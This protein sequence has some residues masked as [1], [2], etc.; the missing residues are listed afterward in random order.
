MW[1]GWGSGVRRFLPPCLLVLFLLWASVFSPQSGRPAQPENKSGFGV[2]FSASLP[3]PSPSAPASY[4]IDVYSLTP[5]APRKT[6]TIKIDPIGDHFVGG[7]PF[8]VHAE[9]DSHLPIS[10]SVKDGPAILSG[11]HVTVLGIGKVR[12]E[13]TQAGNFEYSPAKPQTI[14]FAV[15]DSQNYNNCVPGLFPLAIW[16]NRPSQPDKHSIASRVIS[17]LGSPAPFSFAP[18]GDDEILVYSSRYP[19]TATDKRKLVQIKASISKLLAIPDLYSPATNAPESPVPNATS[20]QVPAPAY[21]LEV[22]VPHAAALGDLASAVSALNS[23]LFK[24]QDAGPGK[25][26]ITSSSLPTCHAITRFLYDIRNLAWQ[27]R[28]V[29]PVGQVFHLSASDV[30]GALNGTGGQAGAGASSGSTPTPSAAS[31]TSSS[32]TAAAGASGQA[33][34]SPGSPATTSAAPAGTSSAQVSS[35][36][37]D[38]LL[39]SNNG[40]GGDAGIEQQKRILALLDLPRPD[41]IINVW[42]VQESTT[43]REAVGQFSGMLNETVTS[44]NDGLQE[45]ILRGWTYLN[46]QITHSTGYFNQG[47][48]DYVVRRYVAAPQEPT[49][50]STESPSKVASDVLEMRLSANHPAPP[51]PNSPGLCG[52]DSYCLGYRTI[53]Q[54]LQPTLT[55][56]FLAILAAESPGFEAGHA[57]DAAECGLSADATCLRGP[58][59]ASG[60]MGKNRSGTTPSP[61]ASAGSSPRSRSL[62]DL[63]PA[64]GCQAVDNQNEERNYHRRLTD[65]LMAAPPLF[66]ECFRQTTQELLC[67][68]ASDGKSTCQRDAPDT[69]FARQARAAIADF[70]FNYKLAQ[71]YPHQLEPYELG[72][73]AQKLNSVFNP[74]VDAFNRDI[75]AYQGFLRREVQQKA[76]AKYKSSRVFFKRW[77][78]IDKQTFVNDGIITVR[79]LSTATATVNTT[80]QNFLDATQ[81]PTVAALLSSIENASHPAASTTGHMTDLLQNISPIQAQVLVGAL[82]AMQSS[83]VQIGKSLD[84][85]VTPRSLN[86]A[87]AAEIN[88]TLNA[89]DVASPTYYAP[90]QSSAANADVSRV[91]THDTTTTVRVDSLKLFD[92]SS[93]S[94]ALQRSRPRFPVIPPFVELPYIGTLAGVPLPAV[95]EYHT[96]TAVLSAIVVPT[97]TDIA[98]GLTFVMDRMVDASHIGDCYWPGAQNSHGPTHPHSARRS[99]SPTWTASPLSTSTR[100]W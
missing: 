30:A 66:L 26:V 44:F 24:V 58:S 79:T 25:V 13:A 47:F 96:S 19:L 34:A 7:P 15:K 43:D 60:S 98:Y 33:T 53:F 87:S 39:F 38:L 17:L 72:L 77:F 99:R 61:A 27:P 20:A 64:S 56:L 49:N 23:S 76:E 65:Q 1:T 40:P 28:Q 92:I 67:N 2:S 37:P 95:K 52:A 55:H 86:G 80:T 45:A 85:S 41:V 8:A 14:K 63:P 57:I 31:P 18:L 35:I 3:T 36:S 68:P 62:D 81:Q 97:A 100:R 91:A 54:P 88:V 12:L 10:L 11:S 84:V 70:L 83:E 69:A 6:Q 21:S 94:A 78:G 42:S 93:F 32:S 51:L 73:S 46:D 48:Y 89:D 9:S 29:S 75:S 59:P 74:F 22:R 90:S 4:L 50:W 71:Q 5:K 16:R 82:N